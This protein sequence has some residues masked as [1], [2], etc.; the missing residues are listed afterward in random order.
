MSVPFTENPDI[1]VRRWYHDNFTVGLLTAGDF[2]CFSLEL[3]FL[4]NQK[5]VSCI[6]EGC[7]EY[8]TR[9]KKT[10]KVLELKGVEGRTYIQLHPGNYTSQI[11]GCCLPGD[12][13]KYLNADSIP[14]VTNSTNTLKRIRNRIPESG[15]IRFWS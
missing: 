11:L 8:Y 7:Y 10:G 1:D 3:P 5:N 14:D 4:D 15:I 9:S 13:I 6:Y 12:S 2:N